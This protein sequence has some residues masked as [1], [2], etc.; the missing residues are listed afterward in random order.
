MNILIIEDSAH[1]RRSLV[2]GLS[3]L[4]FATE[5]TGDGVEGL[6]LA[7]QGLYNVIILDLMLPNLDGI[8]L[9]K[10]IRQHNIHSKVI[11]L[12]ARV[13]VEDRINGLTSGADDYLVKPFSFEEL[14]ARIVSITKRGEIDRFTN[15]IENGDFILDT[16]RKTFSY[17]NQIIDLTKNEF[18]IIEVIFNAKGNVV[19]TS[20]IS[21][22]VV[23]H[24]DELS[25]NAIEAHLSSA[26]KK[27]KQFG[28]VLPIKNK[29]G[30]GYL[31]EQH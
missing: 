4:G 10:A 30:F 17:Q 16:S 21:E 23:G 26:R 12:S 27:V 31:M 29:R 20:H 6:N 24:F 2:V 9:L 19:T 28:G 7:L 5:A 14:H 3:N 15:F 8:S 1:L 13:T 22:L 18:K 11:I 25:K